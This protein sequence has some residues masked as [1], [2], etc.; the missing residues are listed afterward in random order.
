MS[1]KKAMKQAQKMA[2]AKHKSSIINSK[3]NQKKSNFFKK[4]N[5]KNKNNKLLGS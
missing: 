5:T 4:M 2:F 1:S 3:L